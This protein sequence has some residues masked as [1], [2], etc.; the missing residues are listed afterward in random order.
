[1]AA[2]D[3]LNSLGYQAGQEGGSKPEN[4]AEG[5]QGISPQVQELLKLFGGTCNGFSTGWDSSVLHRSSPLVLLRWVLAGQGKGLR[6]LFNL[7]RG[8]GKEHTWAAPVWRTRPPG[9]PFL[10]LTPTSQLFAEH[11]WEKIYSWFCT[12]GETE[13]QASGT[14]CFWPQGRSSIPEVLHPSMDQHKCILQHVP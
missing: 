10:S 2:K 3:Q 1:M 12:D 4:I 7:C 9:L 14:I 5:L 13:A 6:Q 11:L 8:K